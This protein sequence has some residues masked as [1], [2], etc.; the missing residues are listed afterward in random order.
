MLPFLSLLTSLPFT[1]HAQI[2]YSGTYYIA[3][4]G[5]NANNTTTNFYL[6]PTEGWAFYVSDGNVTGDDNGKP[7]LTTYQCRNGVYDSTKAKWTLVK[8]D[9]TPYYYIIQTE[10]GKYMLSNG[11]VCGNPDRVRIHIETVTDPADLN[12]NAL[13]NIY[14]YN[15]SLVIRP[16]GINDGSSTAHTG[17]ENHKWLTVNQGNKPYLYG[18]NARTDG[19]TGFP[20]TGGLVG[21]YTESD[22]NGKFY[23]ED[24]IARPTIS[25]NESNL[26]EISYSTSVTLKYTTDGS[27]P[28]ADHGTVYDGPFDVDDAVTTIKAVAIVGNEVSN[29]ATFRPLVL[30]GSNHK[31]LIQN[32]GNPWNETDLHFYMIPGDP[33][34][35]I[36]KVNTTSL[37]RPSMNW[38]FLNAGTN[39]NTQ[40]YYIVSSV[41]DKRLCYDAT[42]GIYLDT[43]SSPD[44]KFKF[45]VVEYST[46]GTYN[47]IPYGLTSGNRFLHKSNGNEN[48]A[49]VGLNNTNSNAYSQWKMVWPSDLDKTPPFNPSDPA[50]D[51]YTYY[52]IGTGGYYII[53]GTGT[54]AITSNTT[55]VEVMRTMNWYFEVAQEASAS[56]WLTYYHIRNAV[57][58]A[59]LYFTKNQNNDGPCLEMR[60]AVSVG[61]EDRYLFTWAKTANA[62]PCYYI[63]PKL[64]KDVSQNE[65]STLQRNNSN[66]VISILAR[67]AGTAAWTFTES[68]FTCAPPVIGYDADNDKMVIAS[69]ESDAR[70]YYKYG[71]GE[72]NPTTG[73]LYTG[74]FDFPSSTPVTLRVIAARNVDGSDQSEET[75]VIVVNN[76]SITLSAN[77]LTYDHTEQEP[78]VLSVTYND[79]RGIQTI[80]PSEYT[81]GYA[82][83]LNVG[84]ATVRIIDSPGGDYL[85]A[86]STH[87]TIVQ[88]SI[89]DGTNPA[90]GITIN[91]G[92]IG[93]GYTVVVKHNSFTLIEGVGNDYTWTLSGSDEVTV[94]GQNNY[95]GSAKGTYVSVTPG[96]YALHKSGKGYLKRYSDN[97]TLGND[98]TFRYENSFTANGS[99]IW[100]LD[101]YGYLQSD[102]YYLNVAGNNTIY[103]SVTPVTH[104]KTEDIQGDAHGKKRLK[105]NV[106]GQDRYLCFEDQAVALTTSTENCYNAC[107]MTI[108]EASS[109][110]WTGPTTANLTVQSPQQVTYLR[111]CYFT[112]KMDYYEFYDDAGNKKREE[113]K[114]RRIFVTMTFKETND[115]NFGSKWGFD[116]NHGVVYNLL[117]AN[118]DAT[119]TYNLLPADPFVRE[120]HPTPVEKSVKFTLQ[121]TPIL[122]VASMNYVLF[123]IHG[124]DNH[125]YPYDAT[126]LQAGDPVKADGK[127]GTTNT[128]YLTDPSG[129]AG[130][131]QVSWTMEVDP[132]GFYSFKNTVTGR[133]FY[134]DE[135]ALASSDYGALK[136]GATSLQNDP[137]YKFRLYKT[138]D[139]DFGV[140]Y[141]LIPFGK[142]FV[143]FKNDGLSASICSALN[144]PNYASQ[145]TPVVSLHQPVDNSKWCV[146]QYDAEYRVKSDFQIVGPSSTSVTGGQVFTTEGWY[147]KLIKESPVEGDGQLAMVVQGTYNTTNLLQYVWTVEG[148][149]DFIDTQ[150]G[151]VSG[152]QTTFTILGTDAGTPPSFTVNVTSLPVAAASGFIRLQLRGGDGSTYPSID[153][154]V[155]SLH[156]S[157][158]GGGEIDFTP[159]SSLAQITSPTGAYK[160][161]Q[162][163]SAS[164]GMPSPVTFS[165]ILDGDGYTVTDLTTPL[166]STLSNGAVRNLNFKEVTISTVSG[167]PAGAIAG[168]VNGASRIY[169]CGILPTSATYDDH[170]NIVGFSGSS[171]SSEGGFCGGLVGL[172]DGS[173]RVINCFSY[174]NIT[175]G[176]LVGGIVGKN[177][178][179]TTATTRLT[180]VMNCVFY[181]DITGGDS[182]APIYNGEIITN[183]SAANGVNNFNYFRAEASYVQNQ[184]I[185][186]YNCALSAESRFLQRFEFFR[187]LLNS[188]R[189]LAAWWV[190]NDRENKDLIMKWVLL[191]E[192]IG[193]DT[194]FPILK[195]P[196]KYP[197]V[198]NYTPS[199]VAIDPDNVHRNEGR[200]LTNMGTNG[201]LSVTIQMGSQGSAPFGSPSGAGLKSGQSST[202]IKLTINDKDP[203]HFNFNYGKVQLPYYNDY[204]TKNYNGNRVVTGWK[205][206]SI[207]GST[208]GTGSYSTGDE[209][210]YDEDGNI[211]TTPYNFADRTS[212]KKDLFGVSG[213]IFNQGAYWDVPD[214]VKSIT[215]EPYWAKCTYL[216]DAYL[217]VV[218]NQ[219]MDTPSEV[220]TV[221]GGPVY[222]NDNTYDIA[223]D[224]QKVYTTVSNARSAL[225]PQ[226]SHTV[227]DYAIVLV[228]NTH[229]IGISSSNSGQPYTLMSIDLDY[230]NEPDCSY[231][232]RFNSR[233]QTHPVRVDFLNIPGLGMAQ[234]TTGGLGTYNF[235]IMQPVG[236]FE[237]T[238]TSLFRETQFEYD[239]QERGAA[240]LILQG[241]VMEQW[242][243]GQNNDV[244]NQTTYFLVGGNVWFKEFHRGT[245]QDR[246]LQSKHPPV[247]VTGGDFDEF[248]L[249]GLYTANVVSYDD[250][251]ECYID[252]GRFGVVAGAGM[253][254]I[255]D[256]DNHTNGDITW[257]INHADIGEFYAGG[258]NAAK[259]V[260]GN[261]RTFISDSHVNFFCGGPKF[262]DMN[263]GRFVSTT[264]TNCHFGL[265]FGAGYG[266]NSYSRYPPYNY[267]N[268]ENIEWNKWV[269]GQMHATSGGTD[270]DPDY[271]GF[272]HHYSSV[273]EGVDTQIDYQF[274]PMSD[275]A[276][277][278]ARLWI[279]Y[280][281]FSLATT[282]SVTSNLKGCVID[283]SFYGGGRLGKVDGDVVSV[284]EDCT[285]KY[286]V[287]GAGYSATLPEIPVMNTGGFKKEPFYDRNLGAF[288]EAEFPDTL[289]YHWEHNDLVN[290]TSNAINE[291]QKI[292][293]TEEDLGKDNLGSVRNATLTLKGN[294][295]VGTLVAGKGGTSLKPGTGNVF[296]G[297]D[298]SASNGNTTVYLRDGVTVYGN[299]YGGG[300]RGAVQGDSK[301]EIE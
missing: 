40:Y 198:V 206:V 195:T 50:T 49:A 74:A 125:R 37:F 43:Y 126:S 76:L 247:S 270:P 20:N 201:E 133:Y 117:T 96:Y 94:T 265:Y 30:L 275:N 78:A 35:D 71:E 267:N 239:R 200:K 154:E 156:F 66:N 129:N 162:D 60:D 164:D 299:V 109:D 28:S 233:N 52:K 298:E 259:P 123:S 44:N 131:C 139:E 111:N 166:F 231:I 186:V 17:H 271:E 118:T 160:L 229:N 237:S 64:M 54:N 19:P 183:N 167:D 8:D 101:E 251:A 97:V 72:L 53:P 245:H 258:I 180:M 153:S 179:A 171:L 242:V 84:Q 91:V 159:I 173:S 62:T 161:T 274:I 100:A 149:N 12:E 191:P 33:V 266:G 283:S 218:Y 240:P 106:G 213:R 178:V 249:T 289:H 205:I 23:L 34:N 238:N 110:G 221:G 135:T 194:P 112:Q 130:V 65:V 4:T 16:M 59:Y 169:N 11:S 150:G 207:D 70:I 256:P 228:G 107:P 170:G 46:T 272:K 9:D 147:G 241:G 264:A 57:T 152:N 184:A 41:D 99:A 63:V 281:R 287:F 10:T 234:K 211:A 75:S 291:G 276:T 141:Y 67:S 202:T 187:H 174:A 246:S 219:N 32:Q 6:C 13:F 280:V 223:G 204:G 81:V 114:S 203:A 297:G 39:N 176:S 290:T 92:M 93:N 56:D 138:S 144:M 38:Y 181:G 21:L 193:T 268:V 48:K 165:G 142:Q 73:T 214:G 189:S 116:T 15:N 58:G 85:V 250:N 177:N 226:S 128:S 210:T 113:G 18:T 82:N 119:A 90:P 148:L 134:Y 2:D 301:V 277:N 262:G 215:I 286:N 279:E 5:Y 263:A 61:S 104:W 98:N 235:G 273:Y 208:Q 261:I 143:V 225:N 253:E 255:G 36:T 182:K 220:L 199:N 68:T 105:T 132:M 55:V 224:N 95:T 269:N 284:L 79:G 230:D 282:R 14:L 22:G 292:L 29:I 87:F 121:P 175:G 236:W 278:C 45:S 124:D 295:T 232:L 158:F 190:C 296:G 69:T 285:V 216:S 151:T 88:M 157:L 145:A 212:T 163:V 293:Y 257:L 42:N 77:S 185:N 31:R 27:N 136:V 248:Y 140:C 222:E 254:G 197:S 192:N 188:N 24:Y 288:M 3:S 137:Q 244:N 300:N 252:G 120:L 80:D 209:V 108:Q 243:S 172:L 89:G 217:D 7:F 227:Y 47:I 102:Y 260:E 196:A 168:T 83:N 127:G 25:Y 155:E 115:A 122:P 26:I 146:Y 86:G 103:L 294:T 51:S 1:V